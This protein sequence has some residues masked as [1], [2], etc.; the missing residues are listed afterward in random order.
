MNKE[1]DIVKR[2]FEELVNAGADTVF[3]AATFPVEGKTKEIEFGIDG[4]VKGVSNLLYQTFIQSKE[5]AECADKALE[6]ME[7]TEGIWGASE[8]LKDASSSAKD[9]VNALFSS[10]ETVMEKIGE[11]AHKANM[12]ILSEKEIDGIETVE[13]VDKLVN[14][15]QDAMKD[16][17]A[18][19]KPAATKIVKALGALRN[20]LEIQDTDA[21]E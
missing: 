9:L 16:L 18:I 13:D 19:E 12:S 17:P 4:T 11:K 15:V 8:G 1:K 20:L 14:K 10:F 2:L 5:L 3:I 21:D 7:E 6:K